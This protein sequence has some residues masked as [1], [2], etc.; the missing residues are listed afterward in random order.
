MSREREFSITCG[1]DAC[2]HEYEFTAEFDPGEKE[3]WGYSG[4]S[5]EVPP[6]WMI[7]EDSTTC[8]ECKTNNLAKAEQ[9]LADYR[10]EDDR[11]EGDIHDFDNV[12]W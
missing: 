9:I 2:E 12:D 11:D 6:S 4:G 8:P 10:P 5:P 1:N 3:T 7:D